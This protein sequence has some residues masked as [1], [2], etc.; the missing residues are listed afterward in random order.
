[1]DTD[2]RHR[3]QILCSPG[4]HL[5][6]YQYYSCECGDCIRAELP[7]GDHRAKRWESDSLHGLVCPLH[8][9]HFYITALCRMEHHYIDGKWIVEHIIAPDNILPRGK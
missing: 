2:F 3:V 9:I 5:I 4:A 6:H 7:T 1:M 8:P